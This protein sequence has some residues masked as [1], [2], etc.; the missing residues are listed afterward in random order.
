MNQNSIQHGGQHY[1]KL[2]IQP[3]DFIAENNLGYF[4]GTAIKY[5][6][7]FRDKGGVEDLRKA[8][9]FIAKLIELEES[10]GTDLC[11]LR[12][13]SKPLARNGEE[14]LRP[15]REGA[16]QIEIGQCAASGEFGEAS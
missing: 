8:Q 3:W 2:K 10:N 13:A 15:L 5:L 1:K 12:G 6:C 14:S 16:A 9:H 4:E 11:S 7:R